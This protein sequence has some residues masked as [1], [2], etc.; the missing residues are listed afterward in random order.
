MADALAAIADRIGKLLRLLSSDQD[1]EVVAAVR[2]IQ[3]TLEGEKLDIHALADR[4][5]QPANGKKFSEAEAKEIYLRGVTDGRREAEQQQ[6]VRFDC[7]DEPTW[8]KIACACRDRGI[9]RSE[10]EEEFVLDMCRRTVHGGEP[11]EKQ[12]SWLKK[13]YARRS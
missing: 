2:A 12:A 4:I 6:P 3:R 13:I 10:R 1:G 7:V 9:F 5:E 11:T 8:H